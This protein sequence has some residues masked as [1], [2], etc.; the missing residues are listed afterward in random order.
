[1]A[2]DPVLDIRRGEER[3]RLGLGFVLVGRLPRSSMK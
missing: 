1:V 2:E 3:L